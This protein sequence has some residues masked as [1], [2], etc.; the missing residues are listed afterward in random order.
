M[1]CRGEIRHVMKNITKYKSPIINLNLIVMKQNL[2]KAIAF[3]GAMLLS[4]LSLSAAI[5]EHLYMVG[6]ASPSLWHIDLAVEMTNEGDGVFSYRG[7]L[8]KQNLQFIDARNWDTGVRYVPEISGWHL[9]EAH[10]ATILSGIGNENRF[11]V[12]ENGTYEVKVCFGDDGNSVM[13]TGQWVDE[14]APMVVP[15]GAA[16][17][18]WDCASV[19]YPYNIY[20][21]EGTDDIFVY[22]CTVRPG[23]ENKHLKFIEAPSNYWETMFYVA[24]TTDIPNVK[25]VKIGDKLPVHRAWND[26]T[27]DQFWGFRDEDC[28]P[29]LKVRVILNLSEDTIEFTEPSAGVDSPEL[30]AAERSVVATY[31]LTGARVSGNNLDKGIYIVRYSDGSSEKIMK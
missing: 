7:T 21:E 20:P 25:F 27:L 24:E 17:G 30:N 15:L 29:E 31:N 26:G 6:E 11:W 18:Q 14:M 16:S 8:Y 1:A 28:T 5:P 4:A 9:T 2:L 12:P 13:I 22:E 3:G 23:S 10:N 19:P